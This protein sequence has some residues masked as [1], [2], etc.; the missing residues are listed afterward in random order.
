M[1]LSSTTEYPEITTTTTAASE[2]YAEYIAAPASSMSPAA[3][4]EH[5]Q[6]NRITFEIPTAHD[7]RHIDALHTFNALLQRIGSA[8][9]VS[10]DASG[11]ASPAAAEAAASIS[12]EQLSNSVVLDL[13]D[14]REGEAD[15]GSMWEQIFGDAEDVHTFVNYLWIG[16]VTSLV[17]LSL[18]FILFSCYFYRKFRTWKK[19]NKDIRAQIHGASDSYSSH[20]ASHHLISCDASRL[21]QAASQAGP[22]QAGAGPQTGAAGG[23]EAAF[24]QIESPPCYTI[25][26][27]LPSYAEALRHQ[28][29][30]FAY[31]MRFMYPNLAAVHH[32][33]HH[34]HQQQQQQHL[35]QRASMAN[36]E[37]DAVQ[38]SS[39]K[40]QK[41]KLSATG[42]PM[43]TRRQTQ[44]PAQR[45]DKASP[46][47]CINMP[48]EQ[49]LELEQEQEQ[50]EFA[51][52]QGQMQ[53]RNAAAKTLLP[54][55]AADD[56]CASL[57]VVVAA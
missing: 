2:L 13:A 30:H 25:A 44:S 51:Q 46:V 28:P 16:V 24:Y 52:A 8:A 35:S 36:W 50:Q 4:A 32:H 31:G 42:E 54:A 5:M 49:E 23:N 14:L 47:I 21:L 29:R 48:D 22:G 38:R 17:I 26:T 41:C 27:G 19:C 3:I 53:H 55:A 6:Q 40:L 37:K 56:D 34:H 10:Y 9:A 20:G 12:T 33:H 15:G 7:L 43:L 1:A 11:D 45:E 39:N 57:V 18:V